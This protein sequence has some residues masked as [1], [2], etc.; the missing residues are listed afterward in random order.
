M[1]V[2]LNFDINSF[3]VPVWVY[4]LVA[5]IGLVAPVLAAVYPVW[6]G[7]G[8]SIREALA[9][10]GVSQS[11]FGTSAFDRALA[12]MTGIGRPLLLA[13]RNSFRRRARLVLT[14]LTLAL[15][16]LFFMTALN[17]RASFINTLDRAFAAK[18]FD[19]LVNLGTMYPMEKIDR[20][21]KNTPGIQNAEG[22]IA[23]DAAL[24]A[25]DATPNA[26]AAHSLG[27]SLHGSGPIASDRFP[28]IALPAQTSMVKMEII[29]GRGLL[30]GE[31]DTLVLN[32]ALAAKYPQMKVGSTV[33][34]QMGPAQTTWRVVGIARE[35]FFPAIAYVPKAFFEQ[36][37]LH[38]GMANRIS[39]ELA[40]DK[41]GSASISAVRASLD[42]NLEQEGVQALSSSSLIESRF[43]FDQHMLMIYVF[44]I[45]VSCIIGGV[46]GLGLMTTMS[47]NVLERRREMGILRA[48]GASSRM[49]WLMI[50]AEGGLIGLLSWA[51]AALAAWPVSKGLGDLLV[52]L[53]VKS[54]L[55]FHFEL[56]GVLVWLAVSIFLGAASS[57]LPAW[58]ASQRPVREAIGYE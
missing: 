51:L 21:V 3:A 4:L 43:G 50:V 28:V 47:L 32:T 38:P 10:F 9:D 31:I 14:L 42:R 29:E 2:F 45:V 24:S 25:G 5:A 26:G 30:P 41:V 7:S 44:L 46:G 55:D 8:I 54:G 15:G 56:R 22:W 57:F 58:H 11:A 18:K 17:V 12:G 16:G 48:I 52:W 36:S 20:A 19:L 40:K 13:L 27:N 37:F 35:T 34:L 6:E 49:V 53:I 1:A 33:T 39:L 23:T